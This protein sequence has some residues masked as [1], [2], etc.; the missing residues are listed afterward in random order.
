[1]NQ[2]N[3]KVIVQDKTYFLQ[4]KEHLWLS[5]VGPESVLNCFVRIRKHTQPSFQSNIELYYPCNSGT[6]LWTSDTR[7][8]YI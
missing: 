2:M 6:G 4:T 3:E 1:M 7:L 5:F 8:S